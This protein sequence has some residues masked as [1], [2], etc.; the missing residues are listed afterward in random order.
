M[1]DRLPLREGW[2]EGWLDIQYAA[3]GYAALPPPVVEGGA[4]RFG[5]GSVII[6]EPRPNRVI[7]RGPG[8]SVI[9]GGPRMEPGP[10]S[11]GSRARRSWWWVRVARPGSGEGAAMEVD[12]GAGAAR[13][14]A[15]SDAS[16]RAV[17]AHLGLNP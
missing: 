3:S 7:F 4:G 2:T 5:R 14:P 8:P 11:L 15:E 17:A 9:L 6:R 10:W 16:H 12:G 13:M 1:M